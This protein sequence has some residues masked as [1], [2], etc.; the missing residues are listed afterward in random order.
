MTTILRTGVNGGY[1]INIDGSIS[2]EYDPMFNK[3]F[4]FESNGSKVSVNISD[5]MIQTGGQITFNY[6]GQK[7][8]IDDG[9]RDTLVSA[10]Y[11]CLD[12]D[13]DPEDTNSQQDLKKVIF[14]TIKSTVQSMNFNECI[15]NSSRIMVIENSSIGYKFTIVIES[16]NKMIEQNLKRQAL[17]LPMYPTERDISKVS[18]L[19]F[20]VFAKKS[21]TAKVNRQYSELNLLANQLISMIRDNSQV[22]IVGT[23]KMIYKFNTKE[24]KTKGIILNWEEE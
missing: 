22:S 8:I 24:L 6:N 15:C 9:Y 16:I 18:S 13:K 21:H 23:T 5:I 1:F 12:I 20:R 3:S 19:Y 10:G 7:Y 14:D 17:N 2:M 4:E 11:L